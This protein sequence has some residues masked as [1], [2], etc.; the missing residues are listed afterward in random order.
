M[1][2][3]QFGNTLHADLAKM[4]VEYAQHPGRFAVTLALFVL[5]SLAMI[6][7]AARNLPKRGLAL[8]AAAALVPL[9]VLA[10]AWDL[11]RF[12]VVTQFSTMLCVLFMASNPQA[13]PR[14]ISPLPRNHWR[15]SAC[16]V[17]ALLLLPLIYGYFDYTLIDGNAVLDNLPVLGPALRALY[18]AIGT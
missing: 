14:E 15:A 3:W 18:H 17:G 2:K 4:A 6:G 11:S 5:P 10:I 8:F 7:L 16:F 9:S 1:A 12:I 13:H